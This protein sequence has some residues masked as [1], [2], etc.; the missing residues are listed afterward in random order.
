MT[1]SE[2]L[3]TFREAVAIV[4]AISASLAGVLDRSPIVDALRLL[5]RDS[6][7]IEQLASGIES[8]ATV[9]GVVVA[10]I[11][12]W[13]VYIRNRVR[14]PRAEIQHQV[15]IIVLDS[16]RL[17]VHVDVLVRN[18]SE[19]LV[20]LVSGCVRVSRMLPVPPAWLAKPD[21]RGLLNEGGEEFSWPELRTRE[22]D[23]SEDPREIEPRESDSYQFDFLV[24]GPL[25]TIQVYSH[26]RNVAKRKRKIGWNTTSIHNYRTPEEDGSASNS[27]RT[28]T[29]GS[30]RKAGST[31]AG[32]STPATAAAKGIGKM[33]EKKTGSKT[34]PK[35]PKKGP[36]K[37]P[38]KTPKPLKSPP[39]PQGPKKPGGTGH[40]RRRTPTVK[41]T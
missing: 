1:G 9:A 12:T 39:T 25:E 3:A 40:G 16:E 29:P 14:Y 8:L 2:L 33:A 11:W 27:R 10:A 36:A 22:F 18:I 37:T 23:W 32:G 35:Q 30:G 21:E 38:P 41:G 4:A 15:E 20:S 34:P 24:A 13:R 19:V 26:L 17:I 28:E 6:E 31:E 7:P 5:R